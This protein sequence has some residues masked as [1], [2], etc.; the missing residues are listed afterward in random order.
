MLSRDFLSFEDFENIIK[1]ESIIVNC[2]QKSKEN[3]KWEI[4]WK[5]GKPSI[6]CITNLLYQFSSTFVSPSFVNP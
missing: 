3:E 1:F 2:Q 5:C 4:D 6:T